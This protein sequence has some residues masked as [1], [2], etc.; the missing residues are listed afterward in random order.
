MYR[1]PSADFADC[2]IARLNKKAGCEHTMTFDRKADEL[3]DFVLI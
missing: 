3:D 2:L 1:N